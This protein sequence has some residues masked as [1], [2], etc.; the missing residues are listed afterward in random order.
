MRRMGLAAVYQRPRTSVPHPSHMIYPYLLRELT[1][2]R[3]NHVWCADITYVPMR[4]GFLY[5][6]AV[7]DWASRKVLSWRVSNTM[8][9]EFCV[10]AARE[11]MTRHGKP[12][13]FN[14]DREVSSPARSSPACC[15]RRKF[16]YRWTDAVAGWTM[17]SL[18]DCGDR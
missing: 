8:D 10:T 6:V 3:P 2:E 14:T 9:A 11:A 13:I 12:E 7:M 17:C 5:L 16:A 18:N 15:W 1:I 4:R